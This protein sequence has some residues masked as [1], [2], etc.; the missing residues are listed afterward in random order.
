MTYLDVQW[1]H[2]GLHHEYHRVCH[3]R[4]RQAGGLQ[5]E[6]PSSEIETLDKYIEGEGWE[7]KAR[8]LPDGYGAVIQAPAT[9]KRKRWGG[10]VQMG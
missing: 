3:R 7:K 6:H 9:D 10:H 5:T 8:L 4:C 1:L 2:Q